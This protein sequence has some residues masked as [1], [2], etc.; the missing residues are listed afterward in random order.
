VIKPEKLHDSPLQDY[1]NRSVW[2]TWA[3][4]FNTIREK[5][6]HT[7]NL[8]LLWS[9][10]DNKDLWYDLLAAPSDE[11][12]YGKCSS[13]PM[14]SRWIGNIASSEVQFSQAMQLLRNYS[15]VEEITGTSSYTTHPV[16]HQWARHSQGRFFE[17]ELCKLAV[18]V[19]GW[20]MPYHTDSGAYAL[21]RRLLPHA[22]VCFRHIVQREAFTQFEVDQGADEDNGHLGENET[23]LLGLTLLG[24]LYTN[25]RKWL[26]AEEINNRGL[27]GMK[28]V[29]GLSN[30]LTLGTM[31]N[32]GVIYARQER[33]PEAEE[34]FVQAIQGQKKLLGPTH[35]STLRTARNLGNLYR[36]QGK[37]VEASEM[38]ERVLGGQEE[39]L[40]STDMSILET[41]GC[42]GVIYA[43]QGK[44][45]KA[46]Q[47]YDRTLLVCKANLG[48]EGMTEHAPAI[49]V[50]YNRGGLHV[51]QGNLAGAEQDYERALRGYEKMVGTEHVQEHTGALDVLWNLGVVF[52][53][54][55]ESGKAIAV[56]ERALHG[57]SDLYGPSSEKCRELT[58]WIEKLK[59]DHEKN[60]R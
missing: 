21:R 47:M 8:L 15:L 30:G 34:M 24:D 3:I 55:R 38:C 54:Q 33:L 40:E 31:N 49:Q 59:K 9:F 13:A 12:Y 14:L 39:V 36:V 27:G 5:H 42:L 56:C 46:E 50:L 17:M 43:T 48:E 1:P 20:G 51:E 35:P 22:Q 19:V 2:T 10:L 25:Q 60:E 16:V 58:R 26:E 52:E 32:L 23:V 44:L 11:K 37:L 53:R 6:R 28:K 57:Y 45:A 7:A 29:L 41:M 4:S 18:V